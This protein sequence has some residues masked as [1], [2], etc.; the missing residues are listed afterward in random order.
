[1]ASVQIHWE[2]FW[3]DYVRLGKALD[4]PLA[5]LFAESDDL[6]EL[7]LAFS[8]LGAKQRAKLLAELKKI[9]KSEA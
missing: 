4:V 1:M 9:G 8:R 5:Y 3:R 2:A 7:I 6:A